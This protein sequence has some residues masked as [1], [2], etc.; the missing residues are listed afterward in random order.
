MTSPDRER[1][2]RAGLATVRERIAV[3][4]D[5]V[6]RR[7]EEVTLVVVTKAYSSSDM[8]TLARLGVSDVGE[9]REQE[10]APKH[11]ACAGLGLRWHFIGQL[12]T[13]KARR[14]VRFADVVQSVDRIRLVEALGAGARAAD[15]TIECLVQVGLDSGAGR[16]G[17][18]PKDVPA[19]A[20]AVAAQEGLVLRGVMAVA[21]LGADP[22]PAF[23]Q[24]VELQER[25][26]RDHPE[27]TIV[28]AG[29]SGDLEAALAEGATHLRVG[30]AVLGPRPPLGYRP[31]GG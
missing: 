21:P 11:R 10:A 13:N 2:I 17:A 30:S 7:V 28:S 25:L 6:G 18:T 27:A 15:R 5:A 3:A 16:G 9:N 24:L 14:V 22:R 26:L 8:A 12:Q 4:C 1:E 20:G 31:D 23:A 29:M 19:L